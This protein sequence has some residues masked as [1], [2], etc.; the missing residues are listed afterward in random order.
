MGRNKTKWSETK[1]NEKKRTDG[2]V[3]ELAEPNRFKIEDSFK[4]S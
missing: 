1:R 4:I 3:N 2:N